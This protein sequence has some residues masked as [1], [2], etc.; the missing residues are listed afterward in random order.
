MSICGAQA[1]LSFRRFA[2]G[3]RVA[4]RQFG[5]FPGAFAPAATQRDGA[6][7]V[8]FGGAASAPVAPADAAYFGTTQIGL[9]T[10]LSEKG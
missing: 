6:L 10:S 7:H 3:E 1:A 8:S 2:H 5:V 4:W 9:S